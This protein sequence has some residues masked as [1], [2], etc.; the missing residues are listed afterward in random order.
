MERDPS[1]T[2]D[3]LS[4]E[5]F[6]ALPIPYDTLDWVR[7]TYHT[8]GRIMHATY[9]LTER[10]L[11]TIGLDIGYKRFARL[12]RRWGL[13]PF[14]MESGRP[15]FDEGWRRT[16]VLDRT[17]KR[18]ELIRELTLNV[19]TSAKLTTHYVGVPEHIPLPKGAFVWPPRENQ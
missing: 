15:S 10:T 17:P 7:V 2:I 1:V 4:V 5:T 11:E 6:K 12:E 18:D 3:D 9:N 19:P 16:H 13:A 8:D 14:I